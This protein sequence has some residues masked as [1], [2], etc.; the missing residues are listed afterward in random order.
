MV[1]FKQLIRPGQRGKDV[2][3]VKRAM[4]DMGIKGSGALGKTNRA[5]PQFVKV[6]KRVQNQHG[7]PADG[8]YGKATHKFIAPHFD[9]YGRVLYRTAKFRRIKVPKVT[10]LSAQAAARKLLEFAKQGKYHADNP[11]DLRD[12]ERTARGEAVW[13][14]AGR[15][16]HIDKRPLEALVLFIEKGF[17][18]G[19]FAICSDHHYDGP[20]GHAG[21][22]AVDISSINGVSV[23]AHS[24]IAKEAT[25][26]L[27]KVIHN[28]L[29][30]GL[31]AWQ[32]ICDG[33][34][35][36]HYQPIADCTIPGAF[37]YGYSTMS[38]HRNHIH[39][40]YYSS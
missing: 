33:Y 17:K 5:G 34:G 29:P 39:L 9:A 21:G 10:D 37:F 13:S 35:Y 22:L 24:D 25:L 30:A 12:L 8:I 16:L 38:E 32:E 31:H 2:R 11:G 6:L 40:G 1:K 19:T 36:V 20:H 18:I 15:W 27:A 26:K 14:Q 3:A 28:E 7:L 4:L 23:G